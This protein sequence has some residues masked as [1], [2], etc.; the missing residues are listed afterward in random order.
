MAAEDQKNKTDG[1][2]LVREARQ[3]ISMTPALKVA[4]Q[5]AH[6]KGRTAVPM[7]ALETPKIGNQTAARIKPIRTKGGK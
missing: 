7:T 5:G 6:E 4:T 2:L 3:P 1:L